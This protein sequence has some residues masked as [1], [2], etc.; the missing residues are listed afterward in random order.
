M[1]DLEADQ[2]NKSKSVMAFPKRTRFYHAIIDRDSLKA[3]EDFG[4]M[5]NVYVI[6][7]CNY[8]P[9]G[10]DR[11]KYTIRNMCEEDPEMP[12]KDGV[13]TIVLYTRG[14]T[15]ESKSQARADD[16]AAGKERSDLRECLFYKS[17][18]VHHGQSKI[19]NPS[20]TLT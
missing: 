7:L 16:K 1:Y 19:S 11:V 9:F 12:Y 8:D 5:K 3:G 10:Y 15:T 20:T 4:K 2:N 13:Q 17:N 14:R 6:F 18:E